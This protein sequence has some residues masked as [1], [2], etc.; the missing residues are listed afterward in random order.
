M[1]A[2]KTCYFNNGTDKI[3]VI[4]NKVYVNGHLV[5]EINRGV[6]GVVY[7][8]KNFAIKL[9]HDSKKIKEHLTDYQIDILTSLKMQHIILEV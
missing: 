9:Y 1:I 2:N 7:K 3:N 8:Y 6:D 5:D 4:D